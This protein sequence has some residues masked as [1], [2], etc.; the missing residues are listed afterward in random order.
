[1]LRIANLTN[2][3]A[4][5]VKN[6]R[7][8]GSIK[9]IVGVTII[10]DETDELAQ[11][12]YQ[13]YLSYSDIEGVATLFGGWTDHDLSKYS[14]DEDFKFTGAGAIQSMINTWSATI[15]GTEGVKWT[16][17]RVLQELGVGG[18]HL[19]AI[20]S[21]KTVADTMQKWVD[22]AGV[23]GF[24]IAYVISPGS[25]EDIAKFLLP[26]LRRRGVFREDYE[27]PGA[28]MRETFFGDGKGP[29]LR[30]DHPG[31]GFRWRTERTEW[32]V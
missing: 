30:D 20:G 24:N 9:L 17:R 32:D 23:D 11:A 6:G 15:P 19:K 13:E 4:Q 1:M 5:T 7:S 26:E 22:E 27:T 21:P 31:A 14:E 18:F 10:V 28:S 3:S 16:K 2:I 25:F 8:A 12:K 29:K